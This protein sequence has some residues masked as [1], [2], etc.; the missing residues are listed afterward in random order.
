MA[1][2]LNLPWITQM[3]KYIKKKRSKRSFRNRSDYV[4]RKP[5]AF[6]KYRGTRVMSALRNAARKYSIPRAVTPFPNTRVCRHKYMDNIIVPSGAAGASSIYQFRANSVFDPDYTGVGHQPMFHDEMLAQYK[7]YT[8]LKCYIRI[9]I[10]ANSTTN[11][12]VALWCD[13]DDSVPGSA[14]STFEQHKFVGAMKVDKRNSPLIMKGWYDACKWNK[15]NLSGLLGDDKHKT[16][17]GSNPDTTTVKYFTLYCAP[18][19]GSDSLQ[20]QHCTVE[21]YYT[22]MWREPKDHLPS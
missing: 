22:V 6:G 3:V 1:P 9:R 2:F 7:Y 21:M 5:G 17:V 12:S 19:N 20:T 10:P 14:Y 16:A 15:V 18:V 13:D 4:S 8:V 11:Q